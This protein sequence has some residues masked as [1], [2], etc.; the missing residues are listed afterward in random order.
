MRLDDF[1]GDIP[2]RISVIIVRC[3]F[4]RTTANTVVVALTVQ[5]IGLAID[6]ETY[7]KDVV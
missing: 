1:C 3:I 2:F 4:D 6:T 7:L 5:S